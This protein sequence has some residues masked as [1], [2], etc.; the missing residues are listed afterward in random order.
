MKNH[1]APLAWSWIA[2][3]L[4]AKIILHF[5]TNGNY[6]YHRDELLY[7][8]LGNHPDFGHWSNG[9]LI[10]WI[11]WFTQ[12]VLG[13]SPFMIRFIPTLMGCGLIILAASMARDLG[14]GKWAQLLASLSILV[15]P[16]YLRASTMFQPVIFDVFLWTT[17]TFLLLRYLVTEDAKYIIYFGVVF[18]VSLLNKYTPV[19]YFLALLLALLA[20]PHR[21]LLWRKETGIAAACTFVIFLP[22]LLWQKAYNFPVVQHMEALSATQLANVKPLNFLLDQLLLNM[23]SLL[24][25]IGGIYFLFSPKGKSFRELGW[26]F[27]AVIGLFL[28]FKGKSYYSAGIYPVLLAAGAVIWEQWAKPAWAKASLG[29]L[30]VLSILPFLPLGVFILPL[31]QMVDYSNWLKTEVKLDGPLRWEDGIVHDLPQ[32]YADMCGWE[33][34]AQIAQTAYQKAHAPES[35]L[36]YADNYGQ[37]GAVN[38]YGKDIGLPHCN[39][40][41]DNFRLWIDPAF[42]PSALIYINDELGADVEALFEDIQLIGSISTSFAREKGTQVFLC[43]NGKEDVSTFWQERVAFVNAS[44][45]K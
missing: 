5:F 17:F 3:I 26:L 2:W 35:T 33:E 10:G 22:N 9:P 32:D 45:K 7:L 13:D 25:L 8:A 24:L 40:F 43:Q 20:T 21:A 36:L 27:L 28:L 16:M 30:M 4:A 38:L 15:S 31:E 11:S 39:S 18:G 44:W 34:L 41:S 6:S 12:H 1:P 29:T 19:F 42:Q 14:G 37:A 23:P